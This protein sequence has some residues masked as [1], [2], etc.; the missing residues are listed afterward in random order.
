MERIH[1]IPFPYAG[2]SVMV[3]SRWRTKLPD[4]VEL[5]LIELAGRGSRLNEPFY[6]HMEQ[7]VTDLEAALPRAIME[8]PFVLFGYSMGSIIAYELALRLQEKHG[9]SPLY[10]YMGARRAPHAP[11]SSPPIH[12][13]PADA[14]RR[15]VLKLGGMTAEVF[16]NELWAETFLPI[17]RADLKLA[18]RYRPDPAAQRPPL[19]TNMRLFAGK[20]D[21]IPLEHMKAWQPYVTGTCELTVYDGG[22]FFIHQYEDDILQTISND[23]FHYA[24][25]RKISP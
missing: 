18:E 23:L 16:D 7:A 2:S 6:E 5:H 24:E 19:R 11:E 1:F 4:F 20:E 8:E 9:R 22:H 21:V 13:L 3:Y 10:L 14:F 15:E 12:H 17:L 25:K